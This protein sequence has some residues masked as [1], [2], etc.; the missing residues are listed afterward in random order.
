M[1]TAS[2]NQTV[3]SN[4]LGSHETPLETV[5]S[6]Y[7][8]LVCVT[9]GLI[10]IVGTIGNGLVI[11]VKLRYEERSVPNV[12]MI[13]LAF[14]DL[15]FILFVVPITLLQTVMPSWIFGNLICKLTNY[16]LYVTL[17]ATCWTLSAL[18]VDRYH[19]IVNPVNSIKW[20]TL[21][22]AVAINILIW[23]VSVLICSPYI[24]FTKAHVT[25]SEHENRTSTVCQAQWPSELLDK[26]FT[27]T[28]V[29]TTFVLPFIIMTVCYFIILRTLWRKPVNQTAS[30]ARR[31]SVNRIDAENTE[32]KSRSKKRVTK[33]VAF[34]FVLFIICWLPVHVIAICLKFDSNFPRTDTTLFIKLLANTLSYANSC[35]NPFVYAFVHEGFKN[36]IRQKLLKFCVI[37]SFRVQTPNIYIEE[38]NQL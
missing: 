37:C 5:R 1:P 33:M 38:E 27:L 28:V 6:P 4:S 36:N 15:M 23:T 31:N 19:A 29:L 30:S 11:F 24:I 34:V 3:F 10:V 8:I 26:A 9:W 14:T 25:V 20:R 18:T 7:N 17:Y 21:R 13:N 22:K 32:R 35:M 2:I 12:Y 16:L